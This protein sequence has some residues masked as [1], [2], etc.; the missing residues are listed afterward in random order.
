MS[1]LPAKRTL[2]RSKMAISARRRRK[3]TGIFVILFPK[4]VGILTK[5][6]INPPLVS[7]H[8]KTRGGLIIK[9]RT[10]G[11]RRYNVQVV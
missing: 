6:V 2:K 4:K 5:L 7:Q 3:N 9:I 8:L 10:D 11:V 1:Y